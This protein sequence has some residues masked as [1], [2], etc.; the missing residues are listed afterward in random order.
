MREVVDPVVRILLVYVHEPGLVGVVEHVVALGDGGDA[1]A[2]GGL[3]VGGIARA[4]E[5]AAL[6][7]REQ[8]DLEV[9][10][11]LRFEV[12]REPG[13]LGEDDLPPLLG[14]LREVR[15][16]GEGAER[17]EEQ[18]DG[19]QEPLLPIHRP[20]PF[21]GARRRDR[22]GLGPARWRRAGGG[23][24]VGVADQVGHRLGRREFERRKGGRLAEDASPT[25]F[26]GSGRGE[27]R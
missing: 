10:R 19:D 25:I 4:A 18:A 9:A 13:A 24:F 16:E 8:A 23:G 21:L 2:L 27:F 6:P 11:L 7:V 17:D 15:H 26:M 22:R 5:Q 14:L 20:R 12:V 3:D 1:E